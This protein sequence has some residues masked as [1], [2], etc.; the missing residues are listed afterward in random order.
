MDGEKKE[1]IFRFLQDQIAEAP[2]RIKAYVLDEEGKEHPRREVFGKL[3]GFMGDFLKRPSGARCFVLTGL[4]GA[5][6]TT[7]LAQL[8][9]ESPDRDIYKLYL[10]VDQ[11]VSL[12][13]VSLQEV[14]D[15]YEELISVAF[16][17]LDQPLV[18]FLDEI[19]YDPKWGM[20]L[21]SLYDRSRK[22]FV[23]ATGSSALLLQTNADVARRAIFEKLF[24]LR[25][26]EYARIK[27]G[28]E[29]VSGL[30]AELQSA[31]FK[32]LTSEEVYLRLKSKEGLVR[33]Y[34]SHIERL[35]LDRYLRCG[36]LPYMLS[37]KNEAWVYDQIKKTLD[38]VVSVDM[39]QHGK[40]SSEVISKVPGILYRIADSGEL[41][42]TRLCQTVEISKPKLMEILDVLEKTEV[43]LRV[44]PYGSHTVQVRKPSKYLFGAPAFRA[45][46]FN[47]VGSIRSQG[48]EMGKLWEDT[49]GMY[50]T[51]FLAK[52]IH[53]F[54]SY[55]SAQGGADF[56]VGFG[57]E[58]IILE[59]G[60]GNKGFEQITQTSKK[61]SAKYGLVVSRDTLMHARD[62]NVVR[63]P[64]EFFLLM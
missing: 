3:H 4:R 30:G 45:M 51:I 18:L 6:K 43:L 57:K 33:G 12:L 64:L 49:V 56:I 47:F 8:Y 37:L 34:W 59:V 40:F 50:L 31:L 42:L 61:V 60:S 7:L 5:G 25:F 17:R 9:H 11:M 20:V 22:V 2:F 35:E 54:L 41:S 16:E 38:R 21:K 58:R 63:V 29:E 62:A 28:Q 32:S 13:E 10:S 15:V 55:D 36:S 39:A 52:K 26:T 46:Y 53:T 48:E 23:F 27:H 1:K 24:P 14:L 44:Y 19:Q